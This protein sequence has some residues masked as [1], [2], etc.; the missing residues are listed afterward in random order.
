MVFIH[1]GLRGAV[2]LAFAM[3]ANADEALTPALRDIVYFIKIILY[4]KNSFY[5]TFLEF[6]YLH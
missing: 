3:L 4:F 5:L 1:G 6:V 2:G